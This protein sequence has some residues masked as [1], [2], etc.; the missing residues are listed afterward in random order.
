MKST[1]TLTQRLEISLDIKSGYKLDF[2]SVHQDKKSIIA[3]LQ[4][5]GESSQLACVSTL[6]ACAEIKHNGSHEKPV[7]YYVLN[8]KN[9]LIEGKKNYTEIR[10]LNN[11]KDEIEKMTKVNFTVVAEEPT[12]KKH[13]GSRK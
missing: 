6:T 11:I 5:T 4:I 8:P 1:R 9:L 3:V 7:T 13:R 10:S 2:L 12:N